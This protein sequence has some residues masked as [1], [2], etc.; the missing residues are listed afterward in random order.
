ME[1][2]IEIASKIGKRYDCTSVVKENEVTT[3]QWLGCIRE[4]TVEEK[5]RGEFTYLKVV[6]KNGKK[7][8]Y[9]LRELK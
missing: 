2:Y 8:Y 7:E 5:K 1:K 4:H 6:W 9:R 3:N